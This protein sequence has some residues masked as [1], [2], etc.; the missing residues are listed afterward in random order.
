MSGDKR[1]KMTFGV[2][3]REDD[4]TENPNVVQTEMY[5]LVKLATQDDGLVNMR[6][7][8]NHSKEFE[9]FVNYCLV[10]FTQ[11][12]N[13]RYKSYTSNISEIFTESDEGLCML[14]L[15]NNAEDFMKVHETKGTVSRK[16]SNTKY[17]KNKGGP[18]T[19]Y[20]G[21]NRNGIKRFNNLVQIIKRNRES[22]YSKELESKLRVK[23]EDIFR[24]SN[25]DKFHH[26]M[27]NGDDEESSDDEIEAY[28]GFAGL[29]VVSND[30][31]SN[32]TNITEL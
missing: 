17:T 1:L 3:I 23:Y 8:S 30:V 10:H 12:I 25:G 2:D 26:V 19:K 31:V 22:G 6:V 28:D 27:E 32:S 21:W 9:T 11:S 14:I 29:D 16:D 5:N 18:N 24:D 20:K 4:V 13:W 15:E 7:S